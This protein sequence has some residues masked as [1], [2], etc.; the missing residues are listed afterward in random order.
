MKVSEFQILTAVTTKST[1]FWDVTPCSPVE[2]VLLASRFLLVA[3]FGYSSALKM[4]ATRRYIPEYS[5]LQYESQLQ[6]GIEQNYFC[7]RI[8][9]LLL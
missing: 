2:V 8:L 9:G 7:L 5:S 4:E 1:I 6:T 3:C